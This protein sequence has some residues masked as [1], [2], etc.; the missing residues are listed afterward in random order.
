[1]NPSGVSPNVCYS[2][3][4][5]YG[6]EDCLQPVDGNIVQQLM[7]DIGGEQL[8]EFVTPQY[9]VHAQSIYDTLNI[10]SLAFNNVWLIYSA[11]LPQM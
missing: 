3:C 9:A 1:M 11:M 2:L 8:I 5:K 10:Q 7:E 4:T 6:G